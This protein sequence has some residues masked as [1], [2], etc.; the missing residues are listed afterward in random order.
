MKALK[1][2]LVERKWYKE[3]NAEILVRGAKDVVCNEVKKCGFLID[4][5]APIE[6]RGEDMLVLYISMGGYEK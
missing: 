6:L 4:R 5:G 1:K 3:L 2:P